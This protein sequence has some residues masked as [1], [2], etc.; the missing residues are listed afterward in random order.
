M[1]CVPLSETSGSENTSE[2]GDDDTR[3]CTHNET[4][5]PREVWHIKAEDRREKAGGSFSCANGDRRVRRRSEPDVSHPGVVPCVTT[6]VPQRSPTRRVKSTTS[7]TKLL[8]ELQARRPTHDYEAA[9]TPPT[10]R[11]VGRPIFQVR[12]SIR[13]RQDIRRDSVSLCRAQ[14]AR[15][16][17]TA[18][19]S[20]RD[21]MLPTLT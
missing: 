8:C 11:E 2:T 7:L 12:V 20:V 10:G 17:L 1:R 19:Y 9:D 14:T 4:K 21:R 6:D 3:H 16:A 15:A 5:G 18:A 13:P